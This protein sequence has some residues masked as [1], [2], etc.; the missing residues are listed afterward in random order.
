M[1]HQVQ[2]GGRNVGASVP[3]CQRHKAS[4][5]GEPDQAAGVSSSSSSAGGGVSGV[6][7]ADL[8]LDSLTRIVSPILSTG[9]PFSSSTPVT[10]PLISVLLI[11]ASPLAS[12]ATTVIL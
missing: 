10:L 6:A 1:G 7:S 2:F 4:P 8:M 12:R 11:T 9:S 5:F 3:R